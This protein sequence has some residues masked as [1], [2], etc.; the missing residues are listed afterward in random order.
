[1]QKINDSKNSS[2]KI[3]TPINY[4]KLYKKR[5][6]ILNFIM[7]QPY[8]AEQKLELMLVLEMLFQ[9]QNEDMLPLKMKQIL[10]KFQVLEPEKDPYLIFYHLLQQKQFLNGN[11]CEV[12]AGVYPTLAEAVAKELKEKEKTLTIY[13]PQTIPANLGENVILHQEQF[14]KDAN[15]ADIDTLYA[16]FPCSATIPTIEKAIEEN[17]NLLLAFCSCDHSSEQHPWWF[18]TSWAEDYCCELKEQYGKDL[19]ILN[20]PPTY[21]KYPKTFPPILARRKK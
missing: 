12:G 20:W 18:G 13:D 10:S 7:N 15:L 16:L 21:P 6:D 3:I 1:M 8:K 19:E 5:K 14:T 9:E 11:C 17:K 2:K 4:S